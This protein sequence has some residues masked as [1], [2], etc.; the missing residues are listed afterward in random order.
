MKK[1]IA[2]DEDGATYIDV[3]KIT[4]LEWRGDNETYVTLDDDSGLIFDWN[5]DVLANK[6]SGGK[7]L[8]P[9]GFVFDEDDE[10]TNDE[11]PG[12]ITW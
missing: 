10:D 8:T 9:P 1:M 7:A 4:K 6:L 11:D 3:D 12:A 2:V 5:I